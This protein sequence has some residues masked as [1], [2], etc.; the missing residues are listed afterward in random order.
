VLY[1]QL[2]VSAIRSSIDVPE[3]I[4]FPHYDIA[5]PSYESLARIELSSLDSNGRIGIFVGFS[6]DSA[7]FDNVKFISTSSGTLQT[8]AFKNCTAFLRLP[9]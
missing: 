6:A 3:H 8:T 1:K 4:S 7:Q 9:K 2:I 5:Y